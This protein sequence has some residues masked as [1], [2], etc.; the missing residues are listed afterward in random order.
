[1][2][3]VYNFIG[4]KKYYFHAELEDTSCL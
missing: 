4:K 3:F 1:M 2:A